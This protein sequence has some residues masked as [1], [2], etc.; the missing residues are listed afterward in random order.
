MRPPKEKELGR[1]DGL[2]QAEGV[3]AAA[4]QVV[5]GA[6]RHGV[7]AAGRGDGVERPNTVGLQ[8]PSRLSARLVSVLIVSR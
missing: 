7:G 5:C 1:R 8:Q 4:A 3:G 6:Q 2:L